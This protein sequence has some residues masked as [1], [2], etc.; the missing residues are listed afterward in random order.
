MILSFLIGFICA[1]FGVSLV[2]AFIS[3]IVNAIGKASVGVI[4]IILVIIFA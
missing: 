3:A 4:L 2:L 1:V